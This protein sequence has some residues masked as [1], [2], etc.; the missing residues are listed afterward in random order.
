MA[1]S[2]LTLVEQVNAALR[3][4]ADAAGVN[5]LAIDFFVRWHGGIDKWFDANL[6]NRAKQEVSPHASALYGEQ[7]GRL[8]GALRGRSAKCLVLDLDNT[9]WGGVIGDA[10]LEESFWGRGMRPAKRLWTSSISSRAC[11]AGA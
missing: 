11:S 4:A 8:L 2:L 6:W 7:V 9:L 3:P 1:K 10:G 5:L